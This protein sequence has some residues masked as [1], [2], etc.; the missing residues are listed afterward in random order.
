MIIKQ[1]RELMPLQEGYLIR[2]DHALVKLIFLTDD[3]IR[4]RVAFDSADDAALNSADE[5]ALASASASAI[6]AAF[7]ECS[8][9]LVTTAWDDSLDTLLA[10]ERQRIEPLRVPY[11]ETSTHL[12]FRT[13]SLTLSLQK[14]PFAFSLHNLEG[15]SLYREID[16]RAYEKDHMGRLYHYSFVDYDHDHFY[17]LGDQN[18]PLEKMGKH[19]H[20]CPK[21]AIGL[22][23]KYGGPT[24]KHIPF[25]IR[26][27]EQ[28]RHALGLYYNNS[29]DSTF[30]L[31]NERSGYWDRYCYY[32]VDGGDIDLFLINGPTTADVVSRYTLLTGRQTMPTKQ[33]LGFMFTTMYYG[34]FDDH[35]DEAIYKVLDTFDDLELPIDNFG[36]PSGYTTGETDRLRYTFTW[37]YRRFP[38]PETFI[39]TLRERGIDLMPNMKPGLLP[40][41]PN[42][43]DFAREDAFVKEAD[44][45]TDYIGRWWG[46]PG[47]FVDF[48][49]P[50][51]R[52]IWSEL[53]TKT[54]LDKGMHSVWN[55][56]NEYDGVEDRLAVC[57]NEGQG[58]TM[59]WLKPIQ[60]NMM[61][62]TVT[63]AILE[64][65]PNERPYILSRCGFAGIQ[66]YAQTWGG[67][68]HTSWN[69]L[70]YN[71]AMIIGAGL[72]G[73][74]NF[75]CDIG[76]FS[77]PAPSE[78]LLLRWIQNGIFQIRFTMNSASS[79][80]TVTL[81]WMY[82]AILDEIREAMHL[83][84]RLLPYLY[85]L[86]AE[87]AKSGLPAWRPLF[88][89]F[90]DDPQAYRDNLFTFMLGPSLLVASVLEEGA[91]SRKIYL[92]KD[93]EG[94]VW[95]D[96]QNNLKAYE[97]GQTIDY[98]VDYSSIPLFLRGNAVL[99][100]TN[101]IYRITKDNIDTLNILVAADNDS[102]FVYYDDDGISLDYQN[103]VYAQTKIDVTSGETVEIHFTREGSYETNYK[104][105]ALSVIN[106]DRGA[107]WVTVDNQ[108]IKQF[109][110]IYDF[111]LADEGWYYDMSSRVIKTKFAYPNQKDFTVK[112]SF[113]TFDLIGME[114]NG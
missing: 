95:Y 13:R 63:Q 73:L 107:F 40:K 34:E 69:S 54:M 47:R 105:L 37:N 12:I 50:A 66:R 27:N 16:H 93:P 31:G 41:H 1:F 96:L 97:G 87:A 67:D 68:N 42:L 108:K 7:E 28:N 86:M 6:H 36:V 46:G 64:K 2:A 53:L 114:N 21:D 49:N 79:D 113:A 76:G 99:P 55:D 61:A 18:G 9:G 20:L 65:Y 104:T 17:G 10:E 75:G 83:R 3:I 8:Y 92:P 80:N 62:Y 43:D 101:D 77:G 103:G 33:S 22:D 74:A 89:E 51:G 29:H 4:I 94:T 35:A 23:G 57:S 38:S 58:G 5:A 25:Y 91:S 30:D 84:Y 11:E 60:S 71:V 56:N 90:P 44:G 70:K 72:S 26:I 88:M 85:S 15:E 24:Y 112:V 32:S 100:T 111:D 98:P 109:M 45:K 48:T 19:I 52:K 78:E 106:K 81:P 14:N 110:T 59:T 102:S 82:P 39:S